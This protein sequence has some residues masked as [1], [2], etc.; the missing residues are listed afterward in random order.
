MQ[1]LSNIKPQHK[2]DVQAILKWLLFGYENLTLEMVSEIFRINLEENVLLQENDLPNIISS[3]LV[4]L[5]TVKDFRR[6]RTVLQLA[7][8]PVKEYI[9]SGEIKSS[10]SQLFYVNHQLGHKFI[11]QSCLIYLICSGENMKTSFICSPDPV[12]NDYSLLQYAA[13]RWTRHT[14]DLEKLEDSIKLLS[15][16][17]FSNQNG[18]YDTG[19]KLKYEKNSQ[20]L[21]KASI[22]GLTDI[23][24]FELSKGADVNIQGGHYGTALQAASAGGYKDIVKILLEKEADI[25]IQG[26]DYGT[27]LQAASAKGH[28]DIVEI[29]LE[30]GADVNIQGGEYGTALQAASAGGDN[31]IVEILLEMGADVNIQGEEYGTA[32]QAASARGYKDIVEILLEKGADVNIQGGEYGTALQA[33]SAAGHKDIVEIL[34]ERGADVNIQVGQ[35]GNAL[36]ACAQ[37]FEWNY[38]RKNLLE[39]AKTLVK[40]GADVSGNVL[41][42]AAQYNDK[43]LYNLLMDSISS[44]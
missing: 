22:E 5:E 4:V 39:T 10:S 7:H 36:Q 16:N 26:G 43:T 40:N 11:A 3:T 25:N 41:E 42:I 32:L 15:R 6:E 23:V 21:Y 19:L 30:K 35:Y 37:K 1:V 14:R 31:D 38:K 24:Q 27:T 18:A 9:L 20:P 2:E 8:P 34:L 17:L 44:I 29:L 33:A 12:F 13:Q 28:K